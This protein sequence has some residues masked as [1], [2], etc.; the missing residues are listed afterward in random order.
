LIFN[1]LSLMIRHA[2]FWALSL[3]LALS[4]FEKATAAVKCVDDDNTAAT[5]NGTPHYP[6]A[7]IQAGIN[8]AASGDTVKVAAGTYNEAVVIAGVWPEKKTVKLLGGFAGAA[9]AAYTAGTGGDFT[10]RDPEAYTS[11]IIGWKDTFTVEVNNAVACKI[12]GFTIT[13]GDIGVRMMWGLAYDTVSGN[14]IEHNGDF[15]KDFKYRDGAGIYLAAGSHD[16]IVNNIIRNNTSPNRGAGIFVNEDSAFVIK[17][18]VVD[19]NVA[20]GDHGAGVF[21]GSWGYTTENIIQ[22]NRFYDSKGSNWAGG[23]ILLGKHYFSYNIVRDNQS[24]KYVGVYTDE[25]AES[26]I[27]HC[28]I[29]RN[30]A[31]IGGAGI[32]VDEA[33]N[34]CT[35][36]RA[37]ISNCTVA[38]NHTEDYYG[39]GIYSADS[40]TEIKNCIFWG[41]TGGSN[42]LFSA[43]EQC[44]ADQRYFSVTYT[45]STVKQ[46]GVGNISVDPLFADSAKGDFHLK[47]AY[48][49]WNSA[50]SSWVSDAVTSPAIDA[51]D[52]DSTVGLELQPHGNRINMGAYGGTA[53]ASK[54]GSS[55]RIGCGNLDWISKSMFTVSC[56]QYPC[57]Q[58]TAIYYQLPKPAEVSLNVYSQNGKKVADLEHGFRSAGPHQVTWND[59]RTTGYYIIKLTA[60]EY[61][62]VRK[63]I[64]K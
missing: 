51:G 43:T 3:L 19:S 25:G 11:K 6:Y 22:N 9:S 62:A 15:V 30:Q 39:S 4:L 41:N 34:P 61:R 44:G 14:I 45:L 58:S 28:L 12:D 33:G 21:L 24:G 18:N 37:H 50:A 20:Y 53:E 54:S 36:S 35:P 31:R 38:N 57:R 8:G 55:A 59:Q 13:G 5:K 32:G 2:P 23:V 64:V 17:G 27:D 29:Y 42:E 47:S 1:C 60:G 26:W 52:P 40:W 48:G 16:C 10:A 46:P 49:R 7:S 63:V 56:V